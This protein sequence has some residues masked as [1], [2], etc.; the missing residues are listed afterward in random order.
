ME[1]LEQALAGRI[2]ILDGAMGTMLQRYGLSGNSEAFN[3]RKRRQPPDAFQ[4]IE[5]RITKISNN[6]TLEENP[7]ESC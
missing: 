3:R 1:G 5:R 2:L 4:H 6:K 7:R